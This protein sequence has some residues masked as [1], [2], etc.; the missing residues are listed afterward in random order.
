MQVALTVLGRRTALTAE[1]PIDL[2]GT[3]LTGPPQARLKDARLNEAESSQRPAPWGRPDRRQRA[4]EC[5]HEDTVGRLADATTVELIDQLGNQC[6][7]FR[8]DHQKGGGRIQAP[9]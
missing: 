2:T 6:P 5:A 8:A 3:H 9:D 4:Q 7:Q 1:N